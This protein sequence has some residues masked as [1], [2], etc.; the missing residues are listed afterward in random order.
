MHR[1]T[2]SKFQMENFFIIEKSLSF[3]TTTTIIFGTKPV[4]HGSSQA[5]D[6]IG[7]AAA[8]LRHSRSNTGSEPHLGPMLDLNP[9]S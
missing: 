8:Y 9:L 6:C 7:A 1:K 4:A 5:R 3:T 2:E